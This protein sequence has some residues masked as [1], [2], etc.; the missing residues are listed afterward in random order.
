[1]T[2]NASQY[3]IEKFATN[4]DQKMG[5]VD[6]GEGDAIVFFHGNPTS[7]NPWRNVMRHYEDLGRVIAYGMTRM[8]DADTLEPGRP[9]EFCRTWP[10]QHEVSASDSHFRQEDSPNETKKAIADFV[11]HN[12]P[13]AGPEGDGFASKATNAD[14]VTTEENS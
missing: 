14:S 12:Q 11:R 9:R 10:N 8:V 6:E 3:G 2:I 13:W 5:S 7:S 1:M 4:H